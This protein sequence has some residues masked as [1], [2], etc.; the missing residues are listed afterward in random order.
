[1]IDQKLLK[2]SALTEE[3]GEPI[4]N[5]AEAAVRR[6]SIKIV[7]LKIS[8]NSQENICTRV[9]FLI[10]L[11]A[12]CNFIKERDWHRC[13]PVNFAKNF[14]NTSFVKHLRATTFDDA[15]FEGGFKRFME[16]ESDLKQKITS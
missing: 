8:Q 2:I 1:M 9:S 15:G 13:F 10:R 12:V 4:K 11:L 3:I 5:G 16:A 7:F 6:C 14:K